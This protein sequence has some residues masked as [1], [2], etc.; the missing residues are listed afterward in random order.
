MYAI[1]NTVTQFAMA[2]NSCLCVACGED[3]THKVGERRNI[4]ASNSER[5]KELWESLFSSLLNSRMIP[6]AIKSS[7]KMCRKCY[8]AY[9]RLLKV[10][11]ECSVLSIFYVMHCRYT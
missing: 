4:L 9:E 2:A 8:A 6:A 10:K 7:A 3:L 1:D 5:I 11:Q